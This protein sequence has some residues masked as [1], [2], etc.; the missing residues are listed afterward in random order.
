MARRGNTTRPRGTSHAVGHCSAS[1]GQ[2]CGDCRGGFHRWGGWHGQLIR[3]DK[4]NAGG[5][6]GYNCTQIHAAAGCAMRR[7]RLRRRASR[8][9]SSHCARSSS[10]VSSRWAAFA[11]SRLTANNSR[12]H[13]SRSGVMSRRPMVRAVAP[14][15]MNRIAAKGYYLVVVYR[16]N[17]AVWAPLGTVTKLDAT[18]TLARP[19]PRRLKPCQTVGS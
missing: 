2:Y 7:A 11:H 3:I 14:D 18:N 12:W 10:S 4:F 17:R 16:A 13:A 15:D 6:N 8:S 9:T 5:E 19:G 1:H